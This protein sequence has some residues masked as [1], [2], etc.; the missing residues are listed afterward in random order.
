[1]QYDIKL[2]IHGVPKGQSTWGTEKS[3]TVYI[4]TFYGRKSS[5]TA[6]M[7]VEVRQT[8]A[9]TAC[10]YTYLRTG[11]VSDDEGRA[12][13]YFALTLRINYYYA[14]VRNMYNLLDA[15]FNKFIVGSVVS[16]SGGVFKYAIS[17]MKQGEKTFLALE[18]E[19]KN[20]LMQFSSDADFM[21]LTGFKANGQGETASVNLLECDAN[22][23]ASHVKSHSSVAIS[24]FYPSVR[25]QQMEQKMNKQVSEIKSQ[26]QQNIDAT[27]KQAQQNI[28]ETKKQ[29]QQNIDATKKQAQQD[30]ENARSDRDK[31]IQAIKEQY[32]DA[33]RMISGLRQDVSKAKS[34]L[35]KAQ[36]DLDAKNKQIQSLNT[37]LNAVKEY[38]K[39]YA[40]A[41]D[42]LNRLKDVFSK[43]KSVLADIEPSTDGTKQ[44]GNSGSNVSLNLHETMEREENLPLMGIVHKFYPFIDFLLMLILLILVC[45][46]LPRSCE[47]DSD[48]TQDKTEQMTSTDDS[49]Q[50]A[51]AMS[52][53]AAGDEPQAMLSVPQPNM[54]PY[55]TIKIDD[56]KDDEKMQCNKIYKISLENAEGN[57]ESEDFELLEEGNIR[58]K[59]EGNCSISYKVRGV[60]IAAQTFTVT[61]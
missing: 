28:D 36:K 27:K 18:K 8:N 45:F 46:T 7:F 60:T 29:A 22:P 15:A 57:W 21:P 53:T 3:D 23:I 4:E 33:D 43:F 42:E 35:D 24:P 50:T 41:M 40:N 9:G 6:Q 26:A 12:G 39:R 14:D 10:Y 37:E 61:S 38:K 19:L 1:M 20:Y 56:L 16:V 47:G 32:K 25:E 49:A 59:K 30:I 51:M 44:R 58:P 5:L 54:C 48:E 17:D 34:E 11:N 52:D 31:S 13:S 55:A 2:Y